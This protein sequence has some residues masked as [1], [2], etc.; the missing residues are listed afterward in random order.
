MSN[1]LENVADSTDW[2]STPLTGLASVEAALRCQIC[3]DFYKTPMLT[4]CNHTFCSLC[5][6]RALST[7]GRC[8]LCRAQEQ[9]MKLRSNWSMEEVVASFTQARS[10]ILSFAQKPPPSPIRRSET[11]KRRTRATDS[12]EDQG[13]ANKRLRSSA[14]LSKTRSMEATA[15][16]ARREIHIPD[17]EPEPFEPDDGLVACPIC[18]RRMK[19][20]LVDKHLD[21]SCSGEPQ[22]EP[23]QHAKPLRNLTNA[24][25]SSSA[26]PTSTTS[27]KKKTTP[28]PDRL[29]ALNYSMLKDAGLR[30][31]L[32]ELGLTTTGN[33]NMLERRHR[34]WVMIWNANCDSQRPRTVAELRQ[35]LDVW[36]RTLGSRAN[37]GFRSAATNA[38]A[39]IKDKDFD[40][41]AW[42]AK[43]DDAF[44][45]LIANARRSKAKAQSKEDD[46]EKENQ[47][48]GDQAATTEREASVA[49]DVKMDEDVRPTVESTQSSTANGVVITNPPIAIDLTAEDDT[50]VGMKQTPV[51]SENGPIYSI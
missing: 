38:G 1:N 35:D 25:T 46:K 24:F 5:I 19:A 11:P 12:A 50:I 32:V 14:R 49:D 28:A 30:K 48:S 40:G 22:P 41:A 13:P 45:D 31:E 18:W 39:Q 23:V 34:E 7:D 3:K 43:H 6:R 36:E 20:I 26:L 16:M 17:P 9:E 27:T 21:T 44:R 8:P 15:E 2:L 47:A 29:P 10:A 4:S 51:E 42:A 37:I 33:R